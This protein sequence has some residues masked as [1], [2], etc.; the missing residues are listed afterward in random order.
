MVDDILEYEI[1][2]SAKD[3]EDGTELFTPQESDSEVHLD[4]AVSFLRG[5]SSATS[6]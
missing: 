5:I 1:N 2:N 3:I 4:D 6:T